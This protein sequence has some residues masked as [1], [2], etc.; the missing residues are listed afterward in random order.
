MVIEFYSHCN[1]KTSCS[2]LNNSTIQC[3]HAKASS[4]YLFK[5]GTKNSWTLG[6]LYTLV[7]IHST[8]TATPTQGA[9]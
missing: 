2:A 9:M 3:K 8:V 4:P 6:I 1:V 5:E 7:P